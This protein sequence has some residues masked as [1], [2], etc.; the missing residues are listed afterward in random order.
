MDRTEVTVEAYGR[1]VSSG[2]CAPAGFTAGDPRF[3]APA[4]PVVLV[5]WEDAQAYCTFA[6]GRL[7]TEAEWEF[8]ARG[9]RLREF[10]W[11]DTYNPRLANHG[12][13]APDSADLTD[14][15]AGLAPVGSFPDGRTPE[16]L[17]DMAGNAAEWVSDFYSVTD[18]GFGYP[19]ISIMNPKGP[20]TGSR[21]VVRGGSHADGAAWLRTAA[22]TNIDDVRS[23]YVGFRCAYDAGRAR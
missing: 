3:D 23:P 7:P 9:P 20:P 22:R 14:G 15:F 8:A 5:R 16:G 18:R 4:L 17:L 6:R 10:P 19:P 1:C 12:S 21:H 11:G 13:L 2:A